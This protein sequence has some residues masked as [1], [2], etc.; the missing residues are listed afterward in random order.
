MLVARYF[1]LIVGA[2]CVLAFLL[3]ASGLVYV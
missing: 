3:F 1:G 2:A